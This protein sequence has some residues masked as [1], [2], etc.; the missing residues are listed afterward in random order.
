MKY[1]KILGISAALLTGIFAVS[2]END[3]L[4]EI[5]KNMELYSSVY[6][7]LNTHYVDEIDPNTLM[8]TGIDAM[9]GSLDPY[10]NYITE[11]QVQSYRIS[12]D[13]K[14]QGIGASVYKI[15]E[16]FYLTNVLEGGSAQEAGLKAGDELITING[17]AL[18]DKTEN[19]VISLL[20]G[21][22]STNVAILLKENLTGKEINHNLKR[23]EVK[24]SN[25][26]HFDLVGDGVGYIQLTTFTEN[27]AA[28]ISKAFK[29][30]KERDENLKGL[31][32]DLRHNGGGL[33]REAVN[34][35]NLFIPRGK[36]VVTTKGKL[37]DKDNV[38]KTMMTPEDLDIPL[39]VLVDGRSASASEIVSGVLQ[40]Y[41]RAVILG[42]RTYGKG[43][44]QNF[45]EVGYNSRVKVTISK[46]YI[47]S[48]R[49]IQGV[50]YANGD[51]ID[52]PD[53]KRSKFKTKNGRTVLDGGGVTPDVKIEKQELS[54]LM[55][56][57]S[58]QKMVFLYANEFVKK[59]PKF[60]GDIT[61]FNFKE[62]NDFIAFLDKANFSYELEG[63]D[64]YKN[65]VASLDKAEN[66]KKDLSLN[67]KTIGDRFKLEKQ[68]DINKHQQEIIHELEKEIASRYGFE[69]GKS[70]INLRNDAE[71]KEAIN[72]LNNK[73]KYNAIL[74]LN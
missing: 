69:K 47:P 37:R 72:I 38:F 2:L 44:V 64:H 58:D 54:S 1:I 25:V 29:K 15:G 24:I 16:K 34:I 55:K 53:S 63:E 14:F 40:D 20:R 52:I 31:M 26:P 13:E 35:C 22:P 66:L 11:S 27:S 74:G 30:L 19:D 4:F 65:L 62:F 8:K 45:F 51:P 6:K 21:A 61:S 12:D 42:Q 32:I 43:L 48:G 59:N 9:V 57:M 60:D 18:K 73:T 33:L 36:E 67:I 56:A 50:E 41:D 10:T 28:N 3:R 7:M 71:V 49:C 17:S 23:D 46:Y 5:A 70:Q 39:V 68:Q